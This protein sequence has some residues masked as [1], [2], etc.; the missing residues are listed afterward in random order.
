MMTHEFTPTPPEIHT[1]T[2]SS[3]PVTLRR[4]SLKKK[5]D[6]AKEIYR[7]AEATAERA[8]DEAET[9]IPFFT[10]AVLAAQ[11]LSIV[12]VRGADVS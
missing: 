12:A 11:L 4:D 7:Q 9:E 10:N 5:L 8:D 6:A 3:A 2:R 1:E